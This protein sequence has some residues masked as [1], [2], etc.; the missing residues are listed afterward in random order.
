MVSSSMIRLLLGGLGV[1]FL[2]LV[3]VDAKECIVKDKIESVA[4][5]MQNAQIFK[6]AKVSIPKGTSVLVF[7]DV[8]PYISRPSI[9]ASGIGNF[10]ITHTQ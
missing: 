7:N 6:Q 5:F 3:N 10:T 2:F 9:Q 4:V 8:S 1:L